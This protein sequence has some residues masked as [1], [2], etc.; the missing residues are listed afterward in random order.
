[1]NEHSVEIIGSGEGKDY[2]AILAWWSYMEWYR[3]RNIPFDTVLAAYRKRA[4][5]REGDCFLVARAGSLPVGMV[6]LKMDD[7]WSRK[8]L[9]PWLASLYVCPGFRNRGFGTA[10]TNAL[11]ERARSLGYGRLYLFIARTGHDQLEIFYAKRNWLFYDHALDN[12][13]FDTSIY[14]YNL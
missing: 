4:A 10:L 2:A 9:N 7:L 6:S 11:I 5:S 3:Q 12:D 13:G 1:M 8:D 14:C